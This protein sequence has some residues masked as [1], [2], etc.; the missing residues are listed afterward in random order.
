MKK[1]LVLFAFSTL[2]TL[3]AC[4]SSSSGSG[5]VQPPSPQTFTYSNPTP[6]TPDS[7]QAQVATTAQ[8]QTGGIVNA[9]S[10]GSASGAA[11]APDL[12]LSLESEALPQAIANLPVPHIPS[13]QLSASL[14]NG[15]KHISSI[16]QGCYTT[17]ATSLT[18][19]NCDCSEG[20]TGI[21]CTLNGSLTVSNNNVTW[22]ITVTDSEVANGESVTGTGTESGNITVTSSD[23][24]GTI[25][26]NAEFGISETATG[27]SGNEYFA[28][29]AEVIFGDPSS[30]T[31]LVY[32]DSCEGFTSGELQITRT[33]ASSG[34]Y[35]P[36]YGNAGVEFT[37]NGCGNVDVATSN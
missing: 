17:T 29:T 23:T 7:T 5:A 12:A 4:G 8:T 33:V 10:T 35:T 14:Q 6:V 26:G 20:T 3:A 24:G 13:S 11:S 31:P 34:N 37:W 30:N 28:Y 27:S 9:V 2:A 21:T 19:T 25:L 22:S 15:L 36:P 18:Y 16:Q 32:S 1:S